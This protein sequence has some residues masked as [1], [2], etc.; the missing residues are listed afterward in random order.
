MFVLSILL[1]QI[2]VI[3]VAARGLG[4]VFGR[5]HQPQVIGEMLAGIMLGPSLLGWLTPGTFTALFPSSS[6]DF[7][8]AM[9]QI[10]LVVFMFL[11]GL[12]LDLEVIRKRGHSA[13][14]ISHTSIIVPF[15]LGALLAIFLYSKLSIAGV[16]FTGFA[17]FLGVSMSITAFPVLARILS[18]GQMIRTSV[19]SVAMAAAA[20]DDA[21]A[22]TILAGVVL[23]IGA[24]T[25]NLPLWA[26]ILGAVAYALF[27]I[28]LGSRWLK[29]IG[30]NNNSEGTISQNQLGLILLLVLCSALVTEGLGIHPLFGAFLLGVV[31]PKGASLV[32]A[33]KGRLEDLVVVLLL[34]LYFAYTGLRTSVGLI[35]GPALFYFGLI[36]LVAVVGKFC[37]AFFASRLT[38][39]SWR[40]SGSIGVLMNTRGMVELVALNIGLD[41]GVISRL[42]FTLLVLM[43]IITT[44]M[45][46]PILDWIYPHKLRVIQSIVEEEKQ[47]FR[48]PHTG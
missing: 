18:E 48:Q 8:N 23:V 24:S 29:R 28:F 34:P 9:S 17:L 15:V 14:V 10:G 21:T 40:E 39:M 13:V 2:A 12:E 35:S 16:S 42:V 37:G 45:T 36:L 25:T 31:M 1:I 11:V 7:I 27:M 32:K 20:V 30:V 38:G 46:T 22:W 26:I 44:L 33:L 6:L 41:I 4:F 47:S 19:G 43:A 5:F 3:L